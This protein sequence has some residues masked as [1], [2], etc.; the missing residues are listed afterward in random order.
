MKLIHQ[1]AGCGAVHPQRWSARPQHFA[2]RPAC[3][4]VHSTA[5]R[6]GQVATA[7]VVMLA[8]V[9][10]GWAVEPDPTTLKELRGAS[11]SLPTVAPGAK[12][13]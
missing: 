3:N 9:W 2:Q 6:C 12:A 4:A 1:I 5:G 13:G 8:I 11:D 7:G 10:S